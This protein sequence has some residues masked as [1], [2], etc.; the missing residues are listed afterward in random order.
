[1]QLEHVYDLAFSVSP[2]GAIELEQGFGKVQRISL[3]PCH[4]RLLFERTGL[5]LPADELSKRLARQLCEV[6][7]DLC[8]QSG[9]H[10]VVDRA[11]ATLAAYKDGLPESVFPHE[12]YLDSEQPADTSKAFSLVAQEAG[13]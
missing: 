1:M 12:L 6:L 10:P 5:L 3:H 9:L 2:A 11:I 4:V 7:R 13:Q 8:E